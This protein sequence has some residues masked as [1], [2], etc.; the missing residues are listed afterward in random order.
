[1]SMKPK[2]SSSLAEYFRP[3]V[4]AKYNTRF[5]AANDIDIDE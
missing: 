5:K 2:K 1:M 3:A 4:D